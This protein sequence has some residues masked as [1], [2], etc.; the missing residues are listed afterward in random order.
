M[1]RQIPK[2]RHIAP[3]RRKANHFSS[4]T[5]KGLCFD[6]YF[7]PV[8]RERNEGVAPRIQ[9]M[10]GHLFS[11]GLSK[12]NSECFVRGNVDVWATL[13]NPGRILKLYVGVPVAQHNDTS[14]DR[15]LAH[16]DRVNRAV[17]ALNN[18]VNV[19]CQSVEV[20]EINACRGDKHPIAKLP[21][22]LFGNFS[23]SPIFL[24]NLIVV[25]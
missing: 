8:E 7:Q 4:G 6:L 23:Q 22:I 20:A 14:Q 10:L 18:E 15:R 19:R 12:S 17:D 21:E 25:L 13:N 24:S 1:L 9:K 5:Y 2:M 11:D 3:N 16:N